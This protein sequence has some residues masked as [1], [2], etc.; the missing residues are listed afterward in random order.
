MFWEK[1]FHY[2]T[3][4]L[5]ELQGDFNKFLGF[6]ACLSPIIIKKPVFRKFM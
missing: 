1:A 5:L 6:L 3:V 2:Y 4:L